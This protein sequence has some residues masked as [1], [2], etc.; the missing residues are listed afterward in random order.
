MQG[1]WESGRREGS[2]NVLNRFLTTWEK[3]HVHA[4]SEATPTNQQQKV[5]VTSKGSA[6]VIKTQTSDE[7]DG[8]DIVDD[9][10]FSSDSESLSD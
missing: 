2:D 10:T 8:D 3:L 6:P 9:F 4:V 7:R 5:V 1:V